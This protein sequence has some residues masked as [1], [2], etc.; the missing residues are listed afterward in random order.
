[1][2]DLKR[3]ER[4]NDNIV[5]VYN[6]KFLGD[7]DKH[8]LNFMTW[9]TTA[10]S[11]NST[12]IDKSQTSNTLSV[13]LVGKGRK[14]KVILNI[15]N[16][17]FI[18][19]GSFKKNN[20]FLD[21]WFN[22]TCNRF[23]EKIQE[24]CLCSYIKEKDKSEATIRYAYTILDKF[25]SLD[26]LDRM[27]GFYDAH[28]KWIEEEA[29]MKRDVNYLNT[30]L[31]ALKTDVE[32]L[33]KKKNDKE[34]EKEEKDMEIKINNISE[35]YDDS[36]IDDAY[37]DEEK[38][39]EENEDDVEDV[40]YLEESNNDKDD[41]PGFL[42]KNVKPKPEKVKTVYGK[43]D[44][45][46]APIGRKKKEPE[47]QP[48]ETKEEY[49]E[50]QLVYAKGIKKVTDQEFDGIVISDD[51]LV[52]IHN[53]IEKRLRIDTK[54]I[55]KYVLECLPALISMEKEIEKK[56]ILPK[57]SNKKNEIEIMYENIDLHLNGNILESPYKEAY[58][59]FE[60]GITNILNY[61]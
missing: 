5:L 53:G 2:I 37:I 16:S 47:E 15:K 33:D 27:N 21:D 28:F 34:E 54:K 19:E 52:I 32:I 6:Y 13:N 14:I 41:V 24:K 38:Y 9:V 7:S 4:I 44:I 46:I 25:F 18:V 48:V 8:A 1:M 30:L 56:G 11:W 35:E 3:K 31:V 61:F 49:Y 26:K 51:A 57:R 58:N 20:D 40:D 59:E 10:D 29:Y 55:K 22:V 60:S 23:E 50:F 36:D 17:E 12:Y 45:N 39:T 42:K 43:D